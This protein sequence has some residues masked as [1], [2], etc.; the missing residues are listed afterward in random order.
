MAKKQ[1]LGLNSTSTL[2]QAIGTLSDAIP[3]PA[4]V[5]LRSDE[6]LV[7]WSQ[8]TSTRAPGDWRDFDLLLVAKMVRAEAD[9]RKYQLVI[10]KA[11]PLL[12]TDKGTPIVNPL[13]S[14][15]DSL[16]RQQLAIVRSMS[17]TQTE[18]DPRTLNAGGK[19]QQG[20]RKTMDDM[21]NLIARPS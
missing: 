16:Q 3:I 14:V 17:M 10:D 19:N 4:G 20:Y 11:G 8:F 9:I 13:V 18:S 15:V 2:V 21:D 1:R 5:V 7:I 6:E 12:K